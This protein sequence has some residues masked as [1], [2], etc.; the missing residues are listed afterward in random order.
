MLSAVGHCTTVTATQALWLPDGSQSDASIVCLSP[1]A[2]GILG[3]PR[4]V[5]RLYA[6]AEEFLGQH[7]G[8]TLTEVRFDVALVDGQGDT[9]IIENAFGPG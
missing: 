9:R 2:R 6:A 1:P 8:G 5:R 3:S 7:P 4:Q